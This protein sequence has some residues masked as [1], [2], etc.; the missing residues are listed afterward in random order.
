MRIEATGGHRIK[1]RGDKMGEIKIILAG[2]YD[3]L[4]KVQKDLE[5]LNK[6]ISL[7][8]GAI[9]AKTLDAHLDSRSQSNDETQIQDPQH[10]R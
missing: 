7:S 1:T 5:S 4:F 10:C 3:L 6:R 8:A 2:I 9:Q